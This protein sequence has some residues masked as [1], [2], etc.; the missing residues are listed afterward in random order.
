MI[1]KQLKQLSPDQ[2]KQAQLSFAGR[3][4]DGL[5]VSSGEFYIPKV[6]D[7]LNHYSFTGQIPNFVQ[8]RGE[9]FG[10]R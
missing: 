4:V 2:I 3:Y 5:D 10:G 7:N 1:R 6:D 8:A 9:R